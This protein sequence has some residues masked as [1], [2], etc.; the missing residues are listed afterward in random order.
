MIHVTFD[1]LGPLVIRCDDRPVTVPAARQRSL[2]AALLLRANQ[3][4]PRQWLC[5]AVWGARV[6]AQAEVTLRSY[7]MRLRQA[8]GPALATRLTVQPPGYLFRLD[9]D[10]E[11]DLLRLE[12]C[13]R[14]GR[15]AAVRADW[16]GATR[17]FR[18]GLA[19]WRGDPLCDVPSDYLHLVALPRLAEFQAQLW[20]GLCAAAA[21]T[22][23]VAEFVV[24]LQRLTEQDPLSERYAALFMSA[25]ADCDRRVDALAEFRRLRRI[26][27]AEQGVEPGARLQELHRRLLRDDQ[28]PARATARAMGRELAAALLRRPVADVAA[29]LQALAEAGLLTPAEPGGYRVPEQ[30]RVLAAGTTL[31]R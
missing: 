6:S 27:I 16:D 20:E 26:L 3:P 5:E 29:I 1:L 28:L 8:L 25:L 21:R 11:L 17:E 7:V 4:V 19:L 9:R 12:A 15:T 13:L 30:V 18:A 14:R 23:G 24:P 22:G 10:D 31:E 2:L